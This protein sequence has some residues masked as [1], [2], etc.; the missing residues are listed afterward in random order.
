MVR[1]VLLLLLISIEY[2][3]RAQTYFPPNTGG[4]WDTM[5]PSSIGWCDKN[6]DSLY[7][8]LQACHSDG[9]IILKDGK[10]VLEKY[11]GTFTKDSIHI[12]NSASKS[13]TSFLVGMAQYDKLFSLEDS[14]S[15][16]LGDGWTKA[17]LAKERNIRIKHLISMNSGL[18]D[19]PPSP[20]D[21]LSTV[22]TCLLYRVEPNTRWAYH[23]G[24]YKQVQDVISVKSGISYNLYTIQK[25]SNRIGMQGLWSPGGIYFSTTRNMA[26]FGL[27]AL[28]K[29]IWNGDTLMKDTNY[30][31][32]MIQSSQSL[33][34][35]YG[36]LWWLNGKPSY[37]AP[38]LQLVVS[39]PFM[40]NAPAD[41]F[42]ALGKDDQKI[43]IVPSQNLVVARFGASAYGVAAAFSPFDDSLW[44]Y[45]NRLKCT[46]ISNNL[47][48]SVYASIQVYP[49]PS[50][51]YVNIICP[52]ATIQ[53]VEVFNSIGSREY[54]FYATDKID[55]SN[56]PKAIYLLKIVTSDG[57][58][59]RRIEKRS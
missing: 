11:F 32:D 59:I 9:F 57:V 54:I 2:S 10:I 58:Y 31:R 17:P 47:N 43:Y 53:S 18:D 13:L 25:L 41:M 8:Y 23:T 6:V 15:K 28:A 7:Q 42:M 30:Y 4:T 12:W 39:K 5:Q 37:M 49:N 48:N 26:K 24:A 55:V 44:G 33:N 46:K 19:D 27:L 38:G 20:C 56:L 21:N 3:A 35:S 34:L 36:Y 50:A 29:G 45:I 1:Y 14:V 40:P 52:N 22:D 16:Y 51:D